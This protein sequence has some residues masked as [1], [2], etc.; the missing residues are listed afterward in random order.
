LGG[1]D[2]DFGSLKDILL[3]KQAFL[4]QGFV[5]A[6]TMLKLNKHLFIATLS[7]SR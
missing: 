6:E 7:W 3:A 2:R 5:E 4:G 1:L